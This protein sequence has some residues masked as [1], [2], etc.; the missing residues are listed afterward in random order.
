MGVNE[1]TSFYERNVAGA[2]DN[3]KSFNPNIAEVKVIVNGVPNKVYSQGMKTRDTW[4][5]VLKRFGKKNSVMNAA[6]FY[7]RD[8]CALFIDL[9][10]MRDN[11]LHESGLKLVNMKEGVQFPISR[12]AS[13]AG[14]V[15]CHIFILSHAQ[16]SIINRELE[17]VT[18]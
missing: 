8:G 3:E 5:E 10:S 13:G 2:R 7:T 17:S 1:G 18:Y 16:F 11:N 4:E 14:N 15:K 9:R 12:K 6:A